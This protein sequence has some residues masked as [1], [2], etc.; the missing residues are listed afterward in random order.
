VGIGNEDKM[1]PEFEERFTMI[2][3][4]VKEKHPEITIV[5]TAGPFH[6]GEDF[7][8]GW[9]IAKDLNI[10]VVDEHYYTDP[11]WFIDNQH[12]YDSYKRNAGEVYLGEY[13][14]WGNKM[15]NA[16][17]EAAY[18]TSLERNGDVVR[19][20]S[21]APLLAKKN[22]TQW[23]TDMIFFD[24]VTLCP[25][26]NYFVQ[27][28]FSANQGDYYFDKVIAKEEKNINLAASCVQDSKT[29]DIILK[30][31]NYNESAKPMKVN[32]SRF[33]K[34]AAEG[35]KTVLTGSRDAEN[36]FAN[37]KNIVPASSVVKI[38][39]SFDYSAPAMSLTVIRIQTKK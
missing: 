21:Y 37:A 2:S 29:G 25:T 38:S 10:P 9:K 39:K 30:L 8:R 16:I 22:F 12:R 7:D 17:S 3:K 28:M 24:N 15:G 31:V 36:T 4:V 19:M 34:I 5:G 20:A 27:K 33:G 1:T 18:M 26:P 32:L 6:S 23:K 11:K 13:A 35:E 14:S